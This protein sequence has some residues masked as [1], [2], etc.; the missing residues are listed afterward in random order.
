VVNPSQTLREIAK[1]TT[2]LAHDFEHQHNQ[3]NNQIGGALGNAE[4]GMENKIAD[5]AERV[6]AVEELVRTLSEH[7][8]GVNG[9]GG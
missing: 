7:L 1:L 4:L 9:A 3:Q 8:R 2:R 6:A 5:L